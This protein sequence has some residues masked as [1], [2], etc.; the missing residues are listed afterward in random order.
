M[1]NIYELTQEQHQLLDALFWDDEDQDAIHR[2]NAVDG[3]ITR[4]LA[5]LTDLYAETKAVSAIR[6]TALD[7]AK[8]RLDKQLKQSERAEERLKNYI[9]SAML[10]AGIKKIEG[11]ITSVQLVK[12]EV[13]LFGERFDYTQIPDEFIK[14]PPALKE[15]IM[16]TP[17][18]KWAKEH[19]EE[20]D[21]VFV[22]DQP[23]LKEI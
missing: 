15:L 10:A 18:K 17:A 20:L 21:D 16:L 7:E 8:K 11:R 12:H 2:L 13:V 4:K 22:V 6:K 23:F 14:Q 19:I 1:S 9:H 5:Y 3:E